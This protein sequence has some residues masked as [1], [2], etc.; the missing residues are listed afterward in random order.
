MSTTSPR[1]TSKI[2]NGTVQANNPPPLSNV[3]QGGQLIN[4]PIL[5]G[6]TYRAVSQ[7][8]Q[9]YLVVATGSVNMR[10]VGGQIATGNFSIYSVGTGFNTANYFDFVEVQN[11]NSFPVVI[12][13][14]IGFDS[15]IDNRLILANGSN[16]QIIFPTYPVPLSATFINIVDL[17]GGPFT[18][19]DGNLWLALYRVCI[20]FFNLD[21]GNTYKLGEYSPTGADLGKY[22]AA[23]PPAPLPIR[24][25][26][27]GNF[28]YQT[29]GGS[30]N[31]IISEIYSA[32]PAT[33]TPT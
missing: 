29:G 20:L 10:P 31:A 21:S 32:I 15:F 18:D 9:A 6:N 23:I 2:V 5:P 28:T 24:I 25:D 12:S 11:F 33:A 8:T 1:L 22:V 16:P 27:G 26:A 13:L 7:G 17:T 3:R 4:V 14:W 30:V 19:V